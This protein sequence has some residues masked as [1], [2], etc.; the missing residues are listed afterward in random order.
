MSEKATQWKPSMKGRLPRLPARLTRHYDRAQLDANTYPLRN[1]L[2]QERRYLVPTFQ[3]D[4]EWTEDGQWELLFDDLEAVADRLEQARDLAGQSTDQLAKAEKAVA[5]HFLGAIVLDQLPSSAGGIDLRSVIDGQQRLTTLQLLLRGILDVLLETGSGRA[6]QVR[7]LLENPPDVIQHP[8]ELHKLWPRRHD[9]E[10]WELVM[11]DE[12][13]P[14]G[15]GSHLYFK[16]RRYFADRTRAAAAESETSERSDVLVDAALSLFKIVVIDLEDNDDAQIIFEVLNGRQTPLTA[17]DLVKN[18]LF[19]RAEL[20]DEGELEALYDKY[21]APFDESWWKTNVGRGHAARGRRD[22]LLSSWLSAAS[23]SEANVGHLYHETREYVDR[24]G[25]KM[26]DLLAELHLYGLAFESVYGRVPRRNDAVTTAYRHLERLAVTTALPLLLWLETLPDTELPAE[27]H[28]RAVLAVE[29]WVI[30]RIITGANTRGYAKVFIDV[31]TAAKAAAPEDIASAVVNTLATLP[32]SHAWPTDQEV[33]DAFVD[34]RIYVEL[35]QERVR[36]ILGALDRLL[37]RDKLKGEQASF[38]YDKLQI[39]HVMPQ[40]WMTHWPVVDVDEAATELA[41][42][43][44]RATVDRIGNLTLITAPLNA[45]VSNGPWN[46]KRG[47]LRE[48]AQLVL[49]SMVVKCDE[50]NEETIESRGRELARVACRVWT[51]PTTIADT[52]ID[53]ESQTAAQGAPGETTKRPPESFDA[54]DPSRAW[55]EASLFA[56]L[57]ERRGESEARAARDLY[58]WTLANGWEPEFGTGSVA[59]WRPVVPNASGELKPITLYSSGSIAV[60]MKELT[61]RAP[62]DSD[63]T[64]FELLGRVKAIPGLT[65]AAAWPSVRLSRLVQDPIANEELRSVLLW[66]AARSDGAPA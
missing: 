36:M 65:D 38:D 52:S 24:S 57:L 47:G 27:E 14:N 43:R 39:E 51:R 60:Q 30:R 15:F 4:Y 44:R 41:Q 9:R 34:R 33:E 26:P 58:D 21:W 42:Q 64:R 40:S 66:V 23:V 19:L 56:D 17:T 63:S 45:S 28:E 8:E 12:A 1:I 61:A 20:A 62:F 54:S 16:A 10:T 2:S 22:V 59:T 37:Q 25:R 46:T 49:S 32:E 50:W 53:A 6:V 29:S 3:R 55:D 11:S 48:H 7:R 31:L 35:S 5:P 13:S 18:L